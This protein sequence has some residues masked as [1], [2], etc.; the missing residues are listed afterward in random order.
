MT[1]LIDTSAWV[2]YFRGTGTAVNE[3][4]AHHIA[5]RAPFATCG[6]IWMEITAGARDDDSLS[7]ISSVL[8]RGATV[9]TAPHHFDAAASLYRFCRSRGVT[10]RSMI[11]CLIAVVAIENDLEVL[12]NDR[13]F[14][15]LSQ[16]AAMKV[17]RASLT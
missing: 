5:E 10:I 1:V 16:V 2:E 3:A 7:V 12:H 13:D 9:A 14:A 11:D 8:M 15:S 17:H 6:H 4:T